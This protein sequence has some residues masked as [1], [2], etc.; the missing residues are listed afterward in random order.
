M[1]GYTINNVKQRKAQHGE[2]ECKGAYR[3]SGLSSLGGHFGV[4]AGWFGHRSSI[5]VCI[6][7]DHSTSPLLL[8]SFAVETPACFTP[9]CFRSMNWASHLGISKSVVLVCAPLAIR[10]ITPIG[11]NALNLRFYPILLNWIRS[12]VAFTLASLPLLCLS[13]KKAYHMKTHQL[14]QKTIN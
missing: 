11:T 4:V 14:L 7:A 12:L 9:A 6:G 3:A 8:W 2:Q 1:R 13:N 10:Q 5:T